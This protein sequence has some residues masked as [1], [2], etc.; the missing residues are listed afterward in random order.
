[1][2]AQEYDIR[3]CRTRQTTICVAATFLVG[4]NFIRARGRTAVG[5][6]EV[7]VVRVS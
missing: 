3:F 7:G 1:M 6:V 4:V 2:V 5:V